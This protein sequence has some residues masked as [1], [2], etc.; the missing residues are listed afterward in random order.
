[1]WSFKGSV[2]RQKT[3][4]SC[5]RNSSSVVW[6]KISGAAPFLYKN[7]LA[8]GGSQVG[9]GGGRFVGFRFF[10]KTFLFIQTKR[11]MYLLWRKIV[12]IWMCV[13]K[14]VPMCKGSP[15]QASL[16]LQGSCLNLCYPCS[17]P[18]CWSSWRCFQSQLG[19]SPDACMSPKS[20]EAG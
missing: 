18:L 2:N 19:L 3:F 16:C 12:C 8:F 14:G 1:M 20:L 9:R 13:P 5:Y 4:L 10:L 6:W 11:L 7:I 17:D 15:C